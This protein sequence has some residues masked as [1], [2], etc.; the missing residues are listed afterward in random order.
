[1]SRLIKLYTECIKKWKVYDTKAIVIDDYFE[2]PE[3]EDRVW[4]VCPR[5]GERHESKVIVV[6]WHHRED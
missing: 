4:Y 3:G 6:A 1:M 5:C 2:G